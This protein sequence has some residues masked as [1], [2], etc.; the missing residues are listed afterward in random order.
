[1]VAAKIEVLTSSSRFG[2][3]AS[4][5]SNQRRRK[6]PVDYSYVQYSIVSRTVG[7]Y[8]VL[9][10]YDRYVDYQVPDR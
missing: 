4:H 5:A 8:L 3:I 7:K 10:L 6:V 2:L 9:V 1:M